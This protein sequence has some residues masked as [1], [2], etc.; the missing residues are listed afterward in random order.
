MGGGLFSFLSHCPAR[1]HHIQ[2]TGR[3]IRY[4]FFLGKKTIG[5]K[6]KIKDGTNS[7]YH[8]GQINREIIVLYIPTFFIN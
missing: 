6:S 4:N 7:R 1:R 2:Q 8:N 3:T 5:I